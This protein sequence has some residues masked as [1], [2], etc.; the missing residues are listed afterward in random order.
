MAQSATQ[1]TTRPATATRAWAVIPAWNEAES[2]APLL[3]ELS[4]LPAGTLAGIAVGDGGSTD[5]TPDVAR[6]RGALV[7]TQTQR[8]YGAACYAGFLA[9]RAAGAK[10]VVFLDGDG[11]D[12]PSAIPDLLAP[13]SAEEADLVLAVRRPTPSQ[14][15]SIPWHARAGNV[16]VCA[17]L[18]L[19]TG[20]VVSDLPSMK[21]LSVATLESLSMTEMGFGWTTELIAKALRRGLRILEVP[22]HPRP[23][24]AGRSKVSGRPLASARAAASLLRTALQ[25][26]A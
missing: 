15:A 8:G 22:I 25:A 17:L 1:A 4:A 12:P 6:A 3:D 20:R 9:A 24:T 18:R 11:S 2:L 14:P 23:R 16:L 7:A 26:T 10:Q 5:G 13:L 21:A 19:R